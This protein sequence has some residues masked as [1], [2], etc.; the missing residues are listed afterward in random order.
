MNELKYSLK[1]EGINK[2]FYGVQVL[3]DI[4]FL[5]K[6]GEI[7]AL[8][9]ENGAGKSTL[10]KILSGIYKADSGNIKIGGKPVHIQT[11]LDA[12]K[13]GICIVH[14]EL[15]M[16]G[17]MSVTDN[18]FLGMEMVHGNSGFIDKKK[19]RKQAQ[20]MLET[21]GAN[22][23]ADVEVGTLRVAQ[24]QMIEIIKALSMNIKIIIFDEPTSS[25]T[26]KEVQVLFQQMRMLKE[27]GISVIY[28]SHKLEEIMEICDAVTI[29]RDGYVVDTKPI[30]HITVDEIIAKM[31]GREISEMYPA[32][33]HLGTDTILNVQKITN[34]Y[35]KNI[36]FE[37]KK[38]EI[39]GFTGLVGAGRTELARALFGIDRIESGELFINGIS[40]K[41]RT[42]RDAIK[43]GIVLVPEDRKKQGLI[44]SQSVAYNLTLAVVRTFIKFIHVN[45][46]KERK[47]V[48]LYSKKLT[49]KMAGPEQCCM[50]L[51]G[52]NQQ[53]IAISKWL[54]TNPE[55]LILDEPTRGIDVGAKSEIYHLISNLAAEGKAVIVIS[56]E[57]PEILNL[58]SRIAVM[59]EGELMTILDN[60]QRN[61]TQEL[62]MQYA[63]GGKAE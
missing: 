47:I 2:S 13:A 51:S 63:T 29:M 24:Q 59:H 60:S 32:E 22:F 58:S 43:H 33:N 6:P 28:I 10:M 21:F 30:E 12:R 61:I 23:D 41:N 11:P 34:K 35:V 8:V 7:H 25:L 54:A 37:L 17:N 5:L 14:Q 9:G 44:L 20:K 62:I 1:M 40:V 4:H 27:K 39:L 18:I 57:L 50:Y 49:I 46:V 55:I 42:P 56:S 26:S 53:K 3:H 48:D 45:K 16:A 19:M 52:G 15:C 36:S 38:G 31:V